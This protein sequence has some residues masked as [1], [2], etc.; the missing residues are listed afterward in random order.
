MRFQLCFFLVIFCVAGQSAGASQSKTGQ[1]PSAAPAPRVTVLQA[2]LERLSGTAGEIYDMAKANKWNKVRK[3]LEV[4]K[5]SEKAVGLLRKEDNDIYSQRLGKNIEE[6]EH[7]I[8]A[9]N[10][11]E[12]MRSANAVTFLEVA[13]MGDY[14]PRVPTNVKLLDYCG[15]QMEILS[16]AKDLDKLSNL[17]VRMHLIW[18]NLIPRLV[19]AGYT[20]EIKEFSL[21]MKRLD[22]STT[23]EE[24][25]SLAQEVF[26]GVDAME[27]LFRKNPR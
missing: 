12:T 18:Q 6:L 11:L 4:L 10:R 21:V 20:K 7:V 2:E 19:D 23:P 15:R 3:K 5:E 17:V 24:Y 22:R 25:R 26:D 27:K 14:K 16:E 8:S 9:K 1:N 13:L